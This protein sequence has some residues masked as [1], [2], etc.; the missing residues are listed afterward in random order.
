MSVYVDPLRQYTRP[1]AGLWRWRESCHLLADSAEELE[2]FARR[3]RLAAAWR[4]R[5]HYDITA[6]KRRAAVRLGAV[7]ITHR[8]AVALRRRAAEAGKDN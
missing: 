7:E 5:D 1:A 2:A 3:L 4:H 6:V 8:E